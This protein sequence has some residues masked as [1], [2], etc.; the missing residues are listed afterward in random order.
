MVSSL[1]MQV[2]SGGGLQLSIPFTPTPIHGSIQQF[3]AYIKD[4]GSSPNERWLRMGSEID[5]AVLNPRNLQ[6]TMFNKTLLANHLGV[7]R[8][9]AGHALHIL[10][11]LFISWIRRGVDDYNLRL[12]RGECYDVCAVQYATYA[13]KPTLSAVSQLL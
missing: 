7:N 5:G 8:K 9:A 1:T 12:V 4:T 3:V 11:M 10:E 2:V 6:C 13:G